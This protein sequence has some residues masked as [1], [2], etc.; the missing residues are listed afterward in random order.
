MLHLYQ[1]RQTCDVSVSGPRCIW[2][3]WA[4]T[5][6]TGGSRMDPG[7]SWGSKKQTGEGIFL[8]ANCWFTPQEMLKICCHDMRFEICKCIKMRLRTGRRP[9]LTGELTPADRRFTVLFAEVVQVNAFVRKVGLSTKSNKLTYTI[10]AWS[11]CAYGQL[12]S[13]GVGATWG[14]PASWRWG[15]MD[16]L[17]MHTCIYD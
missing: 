5:P 2:C 7:K 15:G 17:L 9:D 11:V 16:A 1:A 6:L 14:K 13:G 10:F 4:C 8:V 12:N 3:A